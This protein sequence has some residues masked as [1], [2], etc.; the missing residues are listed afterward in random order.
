M[1]RVPRALGGQRRHEVHVRD[2]AVA[3]VD[4]AHLTVEPVGVA[5]RRLAV[6][7]RLG[8]DLQVD[9][10]PRL[11]G[12]L[13]DHLRELWDLLVLL[14]EQR[15]VDARMP[16]LLQQLLGHVDVLRALRDRGVGRREPRSER[17]VVGDGAVA[18][19]QRRHHSGAVQRV[20]D[21]LSDLRIV[22]RRLVVSHR[23]LAVVGG[24][25]RD[26]LVG[27]AAQQRGR[28]RRHEL[29]DHVDVAALQCEDHRLLAS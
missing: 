7:V 27:G 15:R 22:E 21:G 26:D 28:T 17:R 3:V 9:V 5:V 11:L 24:L 25:E 6:V 20:R 12:V 4:E 19:E 13:L 10:D 29:R 8:L 2:A 18:A 14:G 16:G 1:R 23:Q